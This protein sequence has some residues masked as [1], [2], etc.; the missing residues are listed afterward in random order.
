MK[1]QKYPYITITISILTVVY[2]LYVNYKISGSL[3][4]NIKIVQLE[5]FGGVTLEHL[6]N[7]EIW[8]LFTS[9]LIHVKQL[10]MLFN[11]VSLALLGIVL[12]KYI[13]ATS[14]FILWFISGTFGTLASTLSVGPPWNLGAGA[15]QAIFGVAA[16]GVVV[17]WKKINTTLLLKLI[18]ASVVIPSLLLDLIYAHHLKLGH[19]VGF[20]VGLG[21]S[22]VYLNKHGLKQY[23]DKRRL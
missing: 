8:R 20:V 15:S 11:V 4:G 9:Q 3:F 19:I 7:L 1:S 2:S 18:V 16:F 13:G 17:F 5:P 14:F 12:E 23:Q 6:W 10:H 21:I 22:L